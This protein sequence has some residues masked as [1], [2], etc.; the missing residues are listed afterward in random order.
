MGTA[1]GQVHLYLF[2][3]C[4]HMYSERRW[5]RRILP[6]GAPTT[7]KVVRPPGSTAA[8]HTRR[9]A[10]RR[11]GRA[12]AGARTLCRSSAGKLRA[13]SE[14]CRC[15]RALKNRSNLALRLVAP[16]IKLLPV[17]NDVG[18]G[19]PRRDGRPVQFVG[20]NVLLRRSLERA[21]PTAQAVCRPWSTSFW[22]RC[23]KRRQLVP[24]LLSVHVCHAL[25]G[26]EEATRKREVFQGR[27]V[28][29]AN[30]RGLLPRL[31]RL[32]RGRGAC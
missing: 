7:R 8:L 23:V 32:R 30:G 3:G 17:C 16:P 18:L 5:A 27:K 19:L 15:I 24:H 21:P 26:P 29:S 2:L 11:D 12:T 31:R 4:K 28:G 14:L 22:L 25:R 1:N 13:G 9:S 10:S 20:G 6:H